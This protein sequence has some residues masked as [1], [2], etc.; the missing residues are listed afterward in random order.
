M[1]IVRLALRNPYS[2]AVMA[3]FFLIMGILSAFS[4]LTDIFPLIDIPVVSVIWAYPGLTAE[5]MESRVIIIN[6]RAFS[7]TVQGVSQ[8]ESQSLPGIGNLRV[9]FQPGTDIGSAVAQAAA[10][11]ETILRI[12]PPGITP[13]VVLPFNA[14]NVPVAQLTVSGDVPEQAL[15]D[16]G[17]N[18]LRIRL[19]TIPGLATPAPYGGAQREINVDVDPAMAAAKG[20][21]P[22]DV[23][24]TLLASNI[25]EPAGVARIGKLEYN[26]LTNS[27]PKSLE[28]FKQFPV[29]IIN[30]RPVRLGEVSKVEDSHADQ[31]NI[32]RVNGKRATYLSILKKADAST[33]DVIG[34][35]KALLPS[36]R[37]DAPQGI[38]LKLDFDQSTFVRASVNSVLQEAVIAAILVSI[39]I[40]FFLG[41]WRSVVIVC[42][43]IPLSILAAIIG[44]KLTGNSINIMTLGGLALSIGM[45]VDDATVEIENINRNRPMSENITVAILR[46]AH[47]IALPAIVTTLAICI[48]FFPIVLLTG[49]AKFL[50]V[51][52]SE[53]VVYAMIISYILSRTLVPVLSRILLRNAPMESHPDEANQKEKNPA[54]KKVEQPQ[55]NTN[56]A[57]GRFSKHFNERREHYLDRLKDKYGSMLSVLLAYPRWALGSFFV[58]FALSLLLPFFVIGTDFFPSTDVGIMRLHFRAPVGSRIEESERIITEAEERLRKII[59]EDEL[60]TINS[61]IGVPTSYNLAFVP[62]DNTASMDT[63]MLI[64]LKEKHRPSEEYRQKIRK[65]FKENFP[66]SVIYFQP[67]DIVSQVLNFGLAAPIDIQFESRDSNLAYDL[68][69]KVRDKIRL[70]PGAEDVVIR[71]VLDYPSLQINVDRERAAHVGITERDASSSLLYALTGSGLVAPNY[72]INP[73]NNVNYQVVTKLPIKQV[74]SLDELLSVPVTGA[75]SSSINQQA[76]T[77][78]TDNYPAPPAQSVGNLAGVMPTT[79]MSQINHVNV[80]KVIDV[81]ASIEGRDLGGVVSDIKRVLKDLGTLPAGLKIH[82]RG[83]NQVMEESFT[84][85]GLGMILAAVLVY[86]LMVTLFQSWVDPLIIMMAV[87]GALSGILWML[88]L[89]GTT[90]NVESLMGTIMA[91]GIAVSN[92]NLMV[93]FA[94]DFRVEQQSENKSDAAVEAALEAGKT[95]LRPVLMTAIAMILGMLPMALGLS[96]AGSQNAPLGRAVIGGLLF[97][98][99]T[100]LFI[101][102]VG[103]AILRKGMPTKHEVRKKYLQ[104]EVP[105]NEELQREV[106][107]DL[108][109]SPQSA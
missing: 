65:D 73:E 104:E 99:I 19:F 94:N 28:D 69:K 23:S 40:L 89:T 44:L 31:T 86:L 98:T 45:L 21:S 108:E 7:T 83:Q 68:A 3:A 59:P 78:A 80:Q 26:V 50:F 5:E 42:T 38:N 72:Y 96:E 49:P 66:G 15:F 75:T 37:K 64:Q 102:P 105:F 74:S 30:G 16:Y 107:K 13:P 43:S 2:V 70:I 35:V 47:Q 17:L 25:I 4:M 32:V 82:F 27:T 20:V 10:V 63:E 34:R 61:N 41:S 33:L 46:G 54:H 97:S 109:Q 106:E 92:S 11:C 67:A 79:T 88:A 48:V 62:T 90:I 14:A 29:K 53:S 103:Y 1:W 52:L 9:Y 93:N 12:L 95:R 87:P 22:N 8:M 58:L 81:L 36:L 56:S 77:S 101:V 6:E 60:E 71:Q 24:N 100:T 76:G 18:F 85:L 39:M 91:I 84:K 51:P 57:T 55:Y